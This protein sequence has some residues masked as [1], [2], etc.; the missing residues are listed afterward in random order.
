MSMTPG[1]CFGTYRGLERSQLS[2]ATVVYRIWED[3]SDCTKSKVCVWHVLPGISPRSDYL[4][5]SCSK[6]LQKGHLGTDGGKGLRT[7]TG[8]LSPCPVDQTIPMRTEKTV[9]VDNCPDES[10]MQNYPVLSSSKAV[11]V[12]PLVS[13]VL[14]AIPPTVNLRYNGGLLAV[15]VEVLT[16]S[17]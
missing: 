15:D 4:Q 11:G 14:S 1:K 3:S 12:S 10:R 8:G 5:A 9:R 13:H 17:L 2:R 6:R 16:P 7:T